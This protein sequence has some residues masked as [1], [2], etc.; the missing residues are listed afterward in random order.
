M[1]AAPPVTGPP[2]LVVSNL[3]VNKTSFS[4]GDTLFITAI[5]TN[6]GGSDAKASTVGFDISSDT[7]FSYQQDIFLSDPAEPLLTAGQSAT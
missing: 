6:Q 7:S 1:Q 2:D 4:S 3:S 5:I